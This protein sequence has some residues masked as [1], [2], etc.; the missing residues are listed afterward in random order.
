MSATASPIPRFVPKAREEE[1]PEEH[2]MLDPRPPLGARGEAQAAGWKHVAEHRERGG[3]QR[4]LA[5][6]A[7]DPWNSERNVA[8]RGTRRRG[9]GAPNRETSRDKAAARPAVSHDAEHE[10]GDRVDDDEGKADQATDLRT[11]EAE[12]SDQ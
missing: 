8:A 6:T 10:A 12:V 7:E 4:G 3:R 11:A 2:L 9:H 1:N 5:E